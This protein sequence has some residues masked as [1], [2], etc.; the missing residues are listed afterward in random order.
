MVFSELLN[1][2]WLCNK[3]IPNNQLITLDLTATLRGSM[4]ANRVRVYFMVMMVAPHLC[5]VSS[6]Y[7]AECCYI[8]PFFYIPVKVELW[9][10]RA[11]AGGGRLV[12]GDWRRAT[13]GWRRRLGL[14]RSAATRTAVAAAHHTGQQHGQNGQTREG[15]RW[16]SAGGGRWQQ[17]AGGCA[18]QSCKIDCPTTLASCWKQI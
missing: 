18:C 11:A 10:Q 6:S 17:A 1:F 2:I 4:F 7:A 15:R 9:Q 5:C 14:V 3:I 8:A 12:A 13:G 16:Q